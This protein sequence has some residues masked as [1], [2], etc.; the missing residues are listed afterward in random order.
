[1]GQS[2]ILLPPL[3]KRSRVCDVRNDTTMAELL[4]PIAVGI[5]LSKSKGKT[6]SKC[7]INVFCFPPQS[8][9]IA[10]LG[11][12]GV[13]QN[14][15]LAKELLLPSWAGFSVEPPEVARLVLRLQQQLRQ[16]KARR[17]EQQQ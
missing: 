6:R 7:L 4:Q 3:K 14:Q 13:A 11:S 15:S 5:I 17:L 16:L 1:M 2:W 9:S 12:S 8:K 10:K